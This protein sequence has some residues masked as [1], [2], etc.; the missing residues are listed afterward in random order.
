MAVKVWALR[1]TEASNGRVG[2]VT[3]ADDELAGQLINNGEAQPLKGRRLK[4]PDPVWPDGLQEKLAGKAAKRRGRPPKA[5]D[6]EGEAI[7]EPESQPDPEPGKS[8]LKIQEKPAK[9]EQP[10]PAKESPPGKSK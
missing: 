8:D 7:P 5:K 6:D 1:R 4:R 2:F 3:I 9:D 10:P